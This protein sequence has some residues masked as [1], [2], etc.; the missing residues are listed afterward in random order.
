MDKMFTF[1]IQ[2]SNKILEDLDE[3]EFC[4]HTWDEALTLYYTWLER[5]CGENPD[6]FDILS[7]EVV[8]NEHDAEY[9]GDEYGTPQDYADM[10]AE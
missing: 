1:N 5:D 8:Y 2:F 4:A 10:M 6:K 7:Q 9:Y 3:V